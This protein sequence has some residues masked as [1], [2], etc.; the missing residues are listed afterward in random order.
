[1]RG[2]E[3]ALP[4]RDGFV[5]IEDGLTR[6]K[7]YLVEEPNVA[8]EVLSDKFMVVKSYRDRKRALIEQVLREVALHVVGSIAAFRQKV[9]EYQWM[10]GGGKG[11]DAG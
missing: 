7:A 9:I 5:Q 11:L 6:P 8:I 10:D 2:V 1:M 4:I 3:I